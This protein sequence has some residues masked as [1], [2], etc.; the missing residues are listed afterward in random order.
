[1]SNRVAYRRRQLGLSQLDLSRASKL[2]R[3]LVSALETGRHVPS[4][5]AA[6]AISQVLGTTVEE[7]FGDA[8]RLTNFVPALNDEPTTASAVVVAMVGDSLA[9]HPLTEAGQAWSRA[10]GLYRDGQIKLFEDSDTAGLIVAGCDPALGLAA[11]LLPNQGPQRIVSIA[12]SSG[13]AVRALD[14]GRLH[15]AVVHG[16]PGQL[17]AGSRPVRRYTIARW[18]VGLACLPGMRIDLEK[19]ARG[20]ISTTR[21]D[22]DAEISQALARKLDQLGGA[23]KIKGPS[24]LTHLDAARRV[25]YGATQVALTME[26]AARAF[27]LDFL[28]LEEHLS[29]LRIDEQWTTLPGAQSILELIS[30]ASFHARLRVIGGYDLSEAGNAS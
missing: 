23:S 26:A 2:S 14:E 5:R 12:T 20:A 22:P 1:M 24:V 10:D 7:L 4:V 28:E 19:L 21:R 27:G 30:S 15:G 11:S 29:E 3:Q 9:Y 18:R 6:L 16:R 17:R 13:K 25:S 8:G